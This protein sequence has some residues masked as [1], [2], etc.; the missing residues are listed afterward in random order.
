MKERDFIN[1]LNAELNT[2]KLPLSEKVKAEPIKK[3]ETKGTGTRSTQVWGKKAWYG[4]GAAALAASVAAVCVL[5]G[6]FPTPIDTGLSPSCM[7]LSVNPSVVALINTD[8]K[9]E[10]VVSLNEDGDTLLVDT[11]FVSSLQGATA[12]EG[13][14]KLAERA[15]RMGYIDLLADG[16]NG[17]NQISVRFE[18]EK[19]ADEGLMQSV[20]AGLTEMFMQKGVLV[21]VDAQSKITDG[22]TKVYNQWLS[23]PSSYLKTGATENAKSTVEALVVDFA[24]DAL[25]E[26]LAQFE[27]YQAIAAANE[28]IERLTGTYLGELF[29]GGGNGYWT[30]D[31]S[32]RAIEGVSVLEADVAAMLERMYYDFGADYRR[33]TTL[34]PDPITGQLFEG[35]YTFSQGQADNA[36]VLQG[37]AENGLSAEDLTA[38]FLFSWSSFV[39]VHGHSQ[40]VVDVFSAVFNASIAWMEESVEEY[41]A[42]AETLVV[43][44]SD[45][46]YQ[47]YSSYYDAPRAAITQQAYENFLEKIE[48]NTKNDQ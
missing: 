40:Q 15:A 22:F 21:Y 42:Q 24:A 39:L 27:L 25:Q 44:W 10:K 32:D 31:D 4:F 11:A 2:A 34:F 29:L 28:E 19:A 3:A 13:A 48:K 6:L 36:A 35:A 37:Y 12:Q 7:Y 5:S 26:S 14:K 23:A 46:L 47:Q 17:Y 41:L 16:T 20:R 9:I 18:G 30:L 45:R 33:L 1:E 8:G 38:E 43:E